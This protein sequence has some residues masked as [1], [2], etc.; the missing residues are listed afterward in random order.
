MEASQQTQT[1]S[2][3]EKASQVTK[4]FVEKT[5]EEVT[6]LM[7][8]LDELQVML[9]N[10]KKME[11]TTKSNSP[12]VGLV[13]TLESMTSVRIPQTETFVV[14]N[15][16]GTVAN[17]GYTNLIDPTHNSEFTSVG[18]PQ[19]ETSLP[20]E[21]PT[22]S[23]DLA[24][25]NELYLQLKAALED[26]QRFQSAILSM[27]PSHD[28]NSDARIEP[29]DAACGRSET[30]VKALS[31]TVERL[32]AQVAAD[33]LDTDLIE[34]YGDRTELEL[35]RKIYRKYNKVEK[36][37]ADLAAK[38]ADLAAM[39]YRAQFL[40]EIVCR[41]YANSKLSHA[42]GPREY[43]TE[44]FTKEPDWEC[45]DANLFKMNTNFLSSIWLHH[46]AKLPSP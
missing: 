32:A 26:R 12:L 16:T 15:L 33:R 29:M 6:T 42:Y 30:A 20:K 13:D 10:A 9:Q 22:V 31:K 27:S 35:M 19:T 41:L 40:G 34:D 3:A 2:P 37:K 5:T 38:Q 24:E 25:L 44:M 18:I 4:A 46:P 45:V 23:L 43:L 14:S 39:A 11:E 8:K 7:T 17:P 36:L 28:R 1:R 21:G